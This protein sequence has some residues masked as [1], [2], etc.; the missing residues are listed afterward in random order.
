MSSNLSCI[1]VDS[2]QK[3][4]EILSENLK[5]LYN[6]IAILDVFNSW[7]LASHALKVQSCDLLFI[8][9]SIPD[10][11]TSTISDLIQELECE[12][13]FVTASPEYALTAFKFSPSGFVLKPIADKE[14]TIAVDKAIDRIDNKRIAR[15]KLPTIANTKIGIPDKGGIDYMNIND[16]I[17]LEAV[18][19]CADIITKKGKITSKYGISKFKMILA[20]PI[21]FQVHRSYIVNMN[22]IIRFETTGVVVMST[23][24]EIPISRNFRD[25]FLV[26]FEQLTKNKA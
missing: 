4:I 22:H 24:N 17:Y 5:S 12:I 3:A 8:D 26:Q 13:I 15:Q 9:I 16:I 11:P 1:I 21:F 23:G 6:R 7:N 25:E 18:N 19:T 2:D 10:M 14:L 20:H